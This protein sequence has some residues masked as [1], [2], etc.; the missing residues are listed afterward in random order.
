MS[1]K[2]TSYHEVTCSFIQVYHLYQ[3]TLSDRT[4]V[5]ESMTLLPLLPLQRLR[6]FIYR[7]HLLRFSQSRQFRF[8][9]FHGQDLAG[10]G[11]ERKLHVLGNEV[12]SCLLAGDVGSQDCTVAHPHM[13][14]REGPKEGT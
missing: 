11:W 13:E 4:S 6:R 5:L 7:L 2:G 1:H 12:I 9:R 8:L 10:L 14:A 3:Y